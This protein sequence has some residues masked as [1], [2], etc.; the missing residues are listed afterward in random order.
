MPDTNEKTPEKMSSED[1]DKA[2]SHH[3]DQVQK[4]LQEAAL[5]RKVR[6][7]DAGLDSHDDCL[8]HRKS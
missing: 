1:L 4:L 3:L 5:R 7:G 2:I 6:Q 8:P